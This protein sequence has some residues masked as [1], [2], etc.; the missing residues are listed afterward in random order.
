MWLYYVASQV[1]QLSGW[2]GTQDSEAAKC[3]LREWSGWSNLAQWLETGGFGIRR[4]QYPT[5]ALI[6]RVW[7]RGKQILGF[8]DFPSLHLFGKTLLC[9]NF[10]NWMSLIPGRLWESLHWIMCYSRGRELKTFEQLQSEF[11]LPSRAVFSQLRLKHAHLAQ[12][13]TVNLQVQ[14]D[15]VLERILKS[16]STAGLIS[17]A[18]WGLLNAQ[19]KDSPLA[20]R[21]KWE[22]AAGPLTEDQW[23]SFLELTPLL[24]LS[25]IPETLTTVSVT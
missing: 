12:S 22:S 8:A 10:V 21:L 15:Y 4:S 18:Y 24:S 3:L 2:A 13:Q 25:E 14:N 9:R 1:Q 16:H 23:N 11:N 19:L 20:I 17:C 5:L 7:D 6:Y